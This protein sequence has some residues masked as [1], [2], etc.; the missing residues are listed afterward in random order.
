MVGQHIPCSDFFA[1]SRVAATAAVIV[2]VM[3]LASDLRAARFSTD[4]FID[5]AILRPSVADGVTVWP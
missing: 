2:A 1:L 3:A 4:R 5:H